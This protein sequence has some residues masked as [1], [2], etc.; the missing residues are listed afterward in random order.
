M[1]RGRIVKEPGSAHPYYELFVFVRRRRPLHL[2]FAV[3]ERRKNSVWI[4]SRRNLCLDLGSV[5]ASEYLFYMRFSPD[6]KTKA[7]SRHALF[8][9]DK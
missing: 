6:P 2:S 1:K 7:Q 4:E 8:V 9:L 3:R 5:V